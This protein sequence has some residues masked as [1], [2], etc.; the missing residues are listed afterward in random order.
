MKSPNHRYFQSVIWTDS[1]KQL[2][3]P[4]DFLSARPTGPTLFDNSGIFFLSH[5]YHPWYLFLLTFFFGERGDTQCDIKK[6]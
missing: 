3:G 1:F 2:I 6:L 4:E 5:I